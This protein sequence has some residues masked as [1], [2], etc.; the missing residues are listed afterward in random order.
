LAM[1]L[2]GKVS[3]GLRPT[4]IVQL[5]VPAS[6]ALP[7]SHHRV[8]FRLFKHHMSSMFLVSVWLLPQHVDPISLSPWKRQQA[9]AHD[10]KFFSTASW[11]MQL[12]YEM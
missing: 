1:P 3:E 9:A 10:W 7:P 2:S 8:L 6:R 5:A 12:N 4:S 11:R